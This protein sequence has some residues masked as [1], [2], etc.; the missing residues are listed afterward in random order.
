MRLLH[1][2]VEPV[3]YLSICLIGISLLIFTLPAYGQQVHQLSYKNTNWTDQNLFGD[4]ADP[5]TG[6]GAFITTPNDQRHVYS[7]SYGNNPDVHQLFYNGASW[8]DEDLTVE[9]GGPGATSG[10]AVTGFSVENYQYVY[11]IGREAHVHQLLYNNIGWG[12]TDLS[13]L[14]GGPIASS[15]TLVAFTTTPDLHVYYMDYYYHHIHQIYAINGTNWQDQ[16][17]TNL[18]GGTVG[19]TSPGWMS[20]FN[21]ANFQYVYFVA[22]T[23]HVHQFLYNNSNWSDEDLTALTRTQPSAAASGVDA[24]VIPGTTKLRVYLTT[25]SGHILQLASTNNAKWTS[26]DLTKKSKGPLA[27][28]T[29]EILA[30]TTPPHNQLHLFYVSYVPADNENHLFQL[31]QP[32]PPTW[33][34]QD[35]TALT[36]GEPPESHAGLAGFSLQ[37]DQYVFY[38]AAEAPVNKWSTPTIDGSITP[39]EYGD[40]NSLSNAGN[41]GQTWYMT[42]D[43]NNLYVGIVNANLAEGAVI[44]VA[45][46]PQT[47]PTC[48]S[49]A[50]GSLA[51]FNYDYVDFSALP[52]RARFVTYVKDG[53]REYRNSDGN[54]GWGPPTSNYGAYAS[55]SANQNTRELAIPWNAITSNGGIPAS[56][57]FFGY[58]AT[59][60]GYVYGQVPSDNNIG[61]FIG[62]NATAT[63][64]YWVVDTGNGTSTPP[65]SNEQPVGYKR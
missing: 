11:Y 34:Y 24:F 55:S 35:M 30:F 15:Q 33:S 13:A 58:L 61:G 26:T 41:T 38:V 51:G 47:P 7:V 64:Y 12:D 9:S 28:G 19:Q 27:N 23:G 4:E 63:Q 20:G 31:S 59:S 36:N 44:Y 18:T 8:S 52:F 10:S 46:N 48:C 53:Y 32:T 60:G 14:T 6:I 45:G 25:A 43:A 65:F 1:N 54:G 17:L 50:D 5:S 16:D 3:P 62:T 21:I 2:V 37:S 49:N 42:W 56:F 39:G 40:D 29:S 22:S 57:V